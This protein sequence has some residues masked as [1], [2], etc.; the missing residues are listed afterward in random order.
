MSYSPPRSSTENY[1]LS[2]L[3]DC[4]NLTHSPRQVSTCRLSGHRSPDTPSKT[5]QRQI[6]DWQFTSHTTIAPHRELVSSGGWRR[7]RGKKTQPY[8]PQKREISAKTWSLSE[9]R[10]TSG[11]VGQAWGILPDRLL[12]LSW[13]S[14]PRDRAA[15]WRPAPAGSGRRADCCPSPTFSTDNQPQENWS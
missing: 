13:T 9:T 11:A 10:Q 15:V 5:F 7:R 6:L 8:P 2:W 12:G 3:S 1:F 14:R 4:N